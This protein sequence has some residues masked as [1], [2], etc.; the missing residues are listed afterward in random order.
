MKRSRKIL[1]VLGTRPEAIKLAPV[2]CSLRQLDSIDVDLCVTAQHRDML[3]QVLKLFQIQPDYDLDLMSCDQ[4]LSSLTCGILHDLGSLLDAANYD[5][6]VLQG[7]TTTAFTASLAA[8]YRHIPVAHVEA[9]LR[10]GDINS[11]WPEELNR[12]MISLAA[13]IHFAPT[14][15]ARSNLLKEGVAQQQVH[16][17]GNTVIDALLETRD[18][19]DTNDAVTARLQQE[20]SFLDPKRKLVLVTG[21][22]RESFGDGLR[23]LCQALQI[24]AKRDDVQ[25]V[26]PVHPNPNV[27]EPVNQA[28][29]DVTNVQLI[30]PQT[31]QAFVYLMN[32]S[33]I[34]ISDS[35]GI[36]EEAPS[37]GKPVLVTRD[38]TE[39]PEAVASGTVK[40]VGTHTEPIVQEASKLLDDPQHYST[41][42]Q[43]TN[44]YGDGQAAQRIAA[45]IHSANES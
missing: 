1:V 10:T 33:Y 5:L 40:L 12:R 13:S 43:A 20:F 32:R 35:G 26:Y 39:R 38:K 11:P 17:T 14:E 16:V 29:G 37:L 27:L 25:I 6:V 30:A 45:I 21:H 22:R 34:I 7:D 36:Q 23:N 8:F 2:I 18:G 31:Y 24:L 19:I 42:S 41:M 15:E 9:G 3:D 4:N 44:P 28:L